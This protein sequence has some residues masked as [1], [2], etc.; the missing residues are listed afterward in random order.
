MAKYRLRYEGFTKKAWTFF[1]EGDENPVW[2][3]KQYIQQTGSP[4][5]G[6]YYIVEV[7]DHIARFHPRMRVALRGEKSR[8]DH[9]PR[10]T[11]R[12]NFDWIGTPEPYPGAAPW[13]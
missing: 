2:L 4:T 7:P 8:A 6:N 3:P 9:A 11:E 1:I 13:E 10:V 5:V 12:V